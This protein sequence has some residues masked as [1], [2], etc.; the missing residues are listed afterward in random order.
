MVATV[1]AALITLLITLAWSDLGLRDAGALLSGTMQN[2]TALLALTYFIVG[3][4]QEGAKFLTVRLFSR[5]LSSFQTL[6]DGLVY[7]MAASLGFA[8]VENLLYA[9]QYGPEILIIRGPLSTLAHLGFGSIWGAALG[10]NA[11]SRN[12]RYRLTWQI[13][14]V[15]AAA[16]MH[17]TFNISISLGTVW[18]YA[19][20]G[21]FALGG[22]VVVVAFLLQSRSTSR[23]AQLDN[24]PW[25]LCS[26]CNARYPHDDYC[27]ECDVPF[28]NP[29]HLFCRSCGRR[30]SLLSKS[31]GHCKARFVLGNPPWT[32]PPPNS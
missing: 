20:S 5:R 24:V 22:T 19:A 32:S 17:G 31:C 12:R 16:A 1:P 21:I 15:V 30:N 9:F 7:A 11:L 27:P 10:L 18:G 29:S 6:G 2:L 13:V 23:F 25:V 26:L 4:V 3:P 8:T 28:Q 14:S